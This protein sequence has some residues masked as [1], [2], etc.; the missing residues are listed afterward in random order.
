MKPGGKVSV[1]DLALKEELPV[2]V[3]EA[4]EALVGCIAGAVRI[5]HTIKMMTEAGLTNI[6]TIEKQ[7][8]L[9]AEDNCNDNLYKTIRDK[10]PKE[11][12]IA[13]YVVSVDFT[14]SKLI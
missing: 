6:K 13:D 12:K 10:L 9:D 1:S 11:K 7:Y 3:R 8:N 14:A 4:V 2:E 5:D